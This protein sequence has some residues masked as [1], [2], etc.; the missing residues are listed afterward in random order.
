MRTLAD[1]ASDGL[2]WNLSSAGFLG[3]IPV[4][5][6]L[7]A[8][9][10]EEPDLVFGH[11]HGNTQSMNRCIPK[12]FV[13][14]TAASIQPVKVFFVC[15]AAEEIEIAD[16]EIGEELAVVVV[17]VVASIQQPV[18]VGFRVNQLWVSI[19]K[20][21]CSRPQR[22]K[23]TRVVEDVHVEPILQ[24]VVPHETKYIV[25]DVTEKVDLM[26]AVSAC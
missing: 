22:G 15:L 24:S 17:S 23:G 13:V 1:N 19:N 7:I 9:I 21:A 8:N 16:L 4:D 14:E 3:H 20:G 11:K 2:A 26:L 12:S 5:I 6:V 25:V 18:E 10:S